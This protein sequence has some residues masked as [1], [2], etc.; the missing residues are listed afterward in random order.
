M[1]RARF[2]FGV[3]EERYR[4]VCPKC[5]KKWPDCKHSDAPKRVSFLAGPDQVWCQLN[6]TNYPS[7]RF[8]NFN[9]FNVVE[10]VM[11]ENQ[12]RDRYVY[13]GRYISRAIHTEEMVVKP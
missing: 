5:K 6:G 8:R 4:P 11:P 1:R 12:F 7:V 13:V 9:D 3:Y 10:M 2:K